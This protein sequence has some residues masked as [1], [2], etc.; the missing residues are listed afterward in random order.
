M[1][2]VLAA[3]TCALLISAAPAAQS[4]PPDLSGRWQLVQPTAADRARDTLE[5]VS[6]DQLLITETPLAMTVEHP[7]TRGTHPQAQTFEIGVA[8]A[9]GR[10]GVQGRRG[11]TEERWSVTYIGTQL[12]MSRTIYPSDAQ[13]LPGKSITLGSIW[14]LETPD[15][16]VIEFGEERPGER[17]KTATRV[18]RRIPLP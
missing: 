17:P 15:R 11:T 6:P 18:Y 4:R 5:I 12:M 10:I 2:S 9:M 14:R 1:R 7:S 8:G 16:L 3:C 13:P